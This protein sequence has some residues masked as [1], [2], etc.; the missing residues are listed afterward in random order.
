MKMKVMVDFFRAVLGMPKVWVA[1]VGLMMAL[2]LAMPVYFIESLEA[3][4][5][6]AAFLAAA[7]LM[8]TLFA[9]K[10]F[11]RLLGLAH[12]FWIPMLP[13]LAGRFEPGLLDTVFGKWLLAVIVVDGISLMIDAVDV[14]R[15][16]RGDREPAILLP[17]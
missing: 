8:M 1:W 12:I 10:G 14:V 4:V 5:I 17:S 6:L 9:L 7:G 11:V 3:R 2:N 15:Y 16:V 13:W